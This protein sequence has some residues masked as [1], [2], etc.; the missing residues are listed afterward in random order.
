M[1][2]L[3]EGKRQQDLRIC[4]RVWLE[5]LKNRKQ[6]IE[7]AQQKVLKR[8]KLIKNLRGMQHGPKKIV[9]IVIKKKQ[10]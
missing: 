10:F 7:D 8:L 3:N 6:D 9:R 1:I 4:Y 5:L 2:N